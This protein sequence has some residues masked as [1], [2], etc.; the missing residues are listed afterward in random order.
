LPSEYAPLL[1]ITANYLNAIC[2]EI[3]DE[4]AS[5]LIKKRVILE[6]KRL[7]THTT[8]TISEISFFLNFEDKSHFGKYFKKSVGLTPESF[9]NSYLILI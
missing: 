7:I 2:R 6:A 9:R 5:F 4:S 8:M 1:H 3:L